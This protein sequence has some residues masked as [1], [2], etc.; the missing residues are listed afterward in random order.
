MGVK[1]AFVYLFST[2]VTTSL[3]IFDFDPKTDT[4]T[5]DPTKDADQV[6]FIQVIAGAFLAIYLL[7]LCYMGA[8]STKQLKSE[9]K[10]KGSDAPMDAETALTNLAL[11]M[12]SDFKDDRSYWEGINILVKL[13]MI[14]GTVLMYKDNRFIAHTAATGLGFILLVW[15]RPYED[16]AGNFVAILLGM[17]EITGVVSGKTKNYLIQLVFAC[18]LVFGLVVA[19]AVALKA[20]VQR[21]QTVQ[22]ALNHSGSTSGSFQVYYHS[23]GKLE[24][25]LMLPVLVAVWLGSKVVSVVFC[26]KSDGV[27]TKITPKGTGCSTEIEL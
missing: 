23:Y 19:L 8:Q 6:G 16:N 18:S 5:M 4:L 2:I 13:V 14:V 7:I 26:I 12:K 17:I 15:G 27:P 20:G 3:V 22:T 24:R 21:L 10:S 1:T 9:L 25:K 11:S